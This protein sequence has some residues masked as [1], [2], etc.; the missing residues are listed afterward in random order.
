MKFASA[1]AL[2]ATVAFPSVFAAIPLV[3]NAVTYF[4]YVGD[5]GNTFIVCIT[6]FPIYF[7]SFSLL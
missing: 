2:F 1:L 3:H 7:F 6:V 4:V 5:G